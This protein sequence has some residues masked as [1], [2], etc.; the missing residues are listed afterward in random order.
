M[1]LRRKSRE[2]ALQMLFQWGMNHQAPP[3]IE[4]SFWKSARGAE[5]TRKF[6]NELFEGAAA[7]AEASDALIENLSK[8]WRI[9]RM[10]E[11]DRAILRLAIYELRAGTAPVKVVI[12]EALELA[13]TF[14]TPESTPFLN[15]VLDSA[16]KSL[17]K[18]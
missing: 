6:A 17:K 2:C 5:T 15:G 8:N 18:E 3:R 1:S 10:P 11:I 9:E 4:A 16:S 13:K 14:S 7:G 12:N